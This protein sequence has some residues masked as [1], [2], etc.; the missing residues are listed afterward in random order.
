MHT[1]IFDMLADCIGHQFAAIR[2]SVELDLPCMGFEFRD[3]DRVC[4]IDNLGAA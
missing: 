3:N 4:G 2:D 1:G